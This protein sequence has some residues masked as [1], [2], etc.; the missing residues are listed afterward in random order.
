MGKKIVLIGSGSQ[1]TEFYLQEMFKYPEFRGVNLAFVDRKPDRLGVVMGIA[2]KINREMGFDIRFEGFGDRREALPGADLVYCFAAINYKE[3]WK[4]ERAICQKHGLNPYEF[5]TSGI[6][7]LSMGSRHIPLVLD[8]CADMEELCPDAWLILDNNPLSKILAAVLRHTKTKCF[9]YCNGHE[10]VQMGVEQILGKAAEDKQDTEASTI[11]REYMVPGG[12][13]NIQAIGVNHL[14]WLTDIRDTATG[15]DLYPEFRRVCAA[16]PIDKI[17]LGYRYSAEMLKR[18]G[19][20]PAPGDTHIADYLWC[21]DKEMDEKCTLLPFDVD[22]WFGGR[23]ADAWSAIAADLQDRDSIIRFINQ[24][25]TGWQSTQ[26][27]RIM[28]GGRYEYFPAINIMNNGCI[29]NMS[30]DAV[31]ELPG[32][33]GPDCVKGLCMGPLPEQVVAFCQLHATQANLIADAAALG[34]KSLALQSMLI[35]P[36]I[37]SVAKAEVLLEDVIAANRKYGS[38]L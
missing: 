28:L 32:V 6:S 7:S 24:R 5:H 36:F 25:R 37:N 34:D 22:G 38:R 4:N 1:F 15:E 8:I 11:A 3:T 20:F 10:L 19:Y 35:D 31:V 14:T 9:G 17:P 29:S 33:L 26:I 18:T 2:D 13:I 27:A 16:T 30:D 12:S 23:D 21:T